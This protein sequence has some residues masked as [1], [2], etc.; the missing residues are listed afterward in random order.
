MIRQVGRSARSLMIGPQ[1][2]AHL[3]KNWKEKTRK[4]R[5]AQRR[6]YGLVMY[7]AAQEE[8]RRVV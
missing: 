4:E 1:D 8:A 3:K 7:R 5:A 6:W 2:E